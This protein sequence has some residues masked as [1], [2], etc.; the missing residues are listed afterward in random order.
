MSIW[1][2]TIFKFIYAL[3]CKFINDHENKVL[4]NSLDFPNVKSTANKP[5]RL[6]K[7]WFAFIQGD[8]RRVSATKTADLCWYF[9]ARL[10]KLES[11]QNYIRRVKSQRKY[12]KTKSQENELHPRPFTFF[13]N[14]SIVTPRLFWS[15]STGQRINELENGPSS[16]W[17]KKHLFRVG[18]DDAI[19]LVLFCMVRFLP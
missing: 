17:Q 13:I 1:T 8:Q 9:K 11:D 7:M 12:S 6:Q 2:R 14:K 4:C 3:A 5:Q 10:M 19:S 16:N 15:K 18:F